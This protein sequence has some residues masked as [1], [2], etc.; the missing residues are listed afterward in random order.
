[1]PKGIFSSY[2]LW[3]T[4]CICIN[5]WFTTMDPLKRVRGSREKSW[6][7]TIWEKSRTIPNI[8][9]N[10]AKVSVISLGIVSW[11]TNYIFVL[12]FKVRG[13]SGFENHFWCSSKEQKRAGNWFNSKDR[14][15]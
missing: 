1:L 11:A 3:N 6:E 10:I 9:E 14:E 12:V 15:P 13:S 2:A 8:P 4:L 5:R 7:K